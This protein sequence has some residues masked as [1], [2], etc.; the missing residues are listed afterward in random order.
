VIWDLEAHPTPYPGPAIG[1]ADADPTSRAVI[2]DAVGSALGVW[3]VRWRCFRSRALFRLRIEGIA[4]GRCHDE[5]TDVMSGTFTPEQAGDAAVDL[6]GAG[7]DPAGAVT[8][9]Q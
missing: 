1:M 4:I 3:L 9:T 6:R 8:A 2:H 7:A 5:R